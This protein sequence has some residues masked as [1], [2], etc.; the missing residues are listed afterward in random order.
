MEFNGATK[1]V[2]RTSAGTL[3]PKGPGQFIESVARKIERPVHTNFDD[4]VPI[5]LIE[6]GSM[7]DEDSLKFR[8]KNLKLKEIFDVELLTDT[9]EHRPYRDA[10]ITHFGIQELQKFAK[11][12]KPT[13]KEVEGNLGMQEIEDLSIEFMK[14]TGS[15]GSLVFLK[16]SIIICTEED[17]TLHLAEVHKAHKRSR[18]MCGTLFCSRPHRVVKAYYTGRVVLL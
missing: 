11:G 18:M 13:I 5:D 10:A 4:Q 3:K 17:F 14:E 1:I 9:S 15:D 2:I 6:M 8:K 16:N 7:L 12:L